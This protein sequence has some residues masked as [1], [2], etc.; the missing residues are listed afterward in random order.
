MRFDVFAAHI[1]SLQETQKLLS[2]KTLGRAVEIVK[3]ISAE[4]AA[5]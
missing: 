5:G 2:Q 4:A 1:A 3:S